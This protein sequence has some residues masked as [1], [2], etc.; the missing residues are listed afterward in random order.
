MMAGD[1]YGKVFDPMNTRSVRRPDRTSLI[2]DSP[3]YC[4]LYY[5]MIITLEYQPFELMR[6]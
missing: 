5:H 2:T 6:M 1:D 3:M 4:S